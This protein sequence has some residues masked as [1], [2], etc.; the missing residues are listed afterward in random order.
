MRFKSVEDPKTERIYL[1][2]TKDQKSIIE[3]KANDCMLSISDFVLKCARG[4]QTSSKTDLH[5]INE[6]RLIGMQLKEIYQ[7]EQ[8]RNATE[9]D[10]VMQSII[11]KISEIG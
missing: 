5:F 3:Q 7:A 8:P 2:V 10:P 6:L 1:R 4:R 9:L 11:K